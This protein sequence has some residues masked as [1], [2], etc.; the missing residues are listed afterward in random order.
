MRRQTNKGKSSV[1]AMAARTHALSKIA[2]L[3]AELAD[4][5]MIEREVVRQIVGGVKATR[6]HNQVHKNACDRIAEIEIELARLKRL[7]T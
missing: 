4:R 7:W 3:E 5:R 2:R 6:A 1:H